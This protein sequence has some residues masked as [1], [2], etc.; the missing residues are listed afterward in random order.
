M[1]CG[2]GATLVHLGSPSGATGI[3]L[4]E[5]KVAVAKELLPRCEFVS[6]SVY[7]LPFKDNSFDQLIVRD[8]VHHLEEPGRFVEECARVLAKGGRIDVLEPCR[9]NPLIFLHALTNRVE[10][11]EL[12]S[13]PTYLVSKIQRRF[14][15]VS[16]NRYQPFPVHRIVYHPSL[17]RPALASTWVSHVV[18]VAELLAEKFAPRWTWAYIHVRSFSKK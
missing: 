16:V 6:G 13:T 1:G 7:E 11:G 10:R 15:V 2:E 12:R 17:G 8:L 14:R 3:D 9:Y 4:F 5:D 18:D